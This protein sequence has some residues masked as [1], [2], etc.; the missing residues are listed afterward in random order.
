LIPPEVAR[1][2]LLGVRKQSVAMQ[3]MRKLPNMKTGTQKQPVLSMLP[4]ADFVNGDAGMKVTTQAKWEKKQMVAGEIAAIIPVPQAVI[5]DAD[6]DL[7]GE[8]RPLIEESIGRVF[9]NQVFNGGNPKAPAEW[10]QALIAAATSAGNVVTLG[11]G[12]DVA[13]DISELYGILEDLEYDVTGLAA[14]KGLKRQLRNLRDLNGSPIFQPIADGQPGTVYDVP[15]VFV[16][17]GAWDKD[18]ATA[19]AGEWTDAAY[20]MRQDITFQIFDTGVIS[21]DDG[22]VVYNLLQ[23][24]MVAMRAVMRVA[25]QV[26]NPIDIDRPYGTGFPFAVL[27]SA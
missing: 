22:K 6:Y 12:A 4:Q 15:T 13:E 26:A 1:E 24:D 23:Q 8:V 5:D 14:Q 20:A 16:P 27:K 21:D 18:D 7:W 25:W 2:I 19:V 11:T 3:L 10:P 9:D 17:K